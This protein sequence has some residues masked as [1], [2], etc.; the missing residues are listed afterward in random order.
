MGDMWSFQDITDISVRLSDY[1]VVAT[2][3]PG[4]LPKSLGFSAFNLGNASSEQCSVKSR[5]KPDV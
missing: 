3:A 4:L 5:N 2:K 1:L